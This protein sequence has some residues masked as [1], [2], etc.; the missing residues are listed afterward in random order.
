MIK[1]KELHFQRQ[2]IFIASS[3]HIGKLWKVENAH[4]KGMHYIRKKTALKFVV[5]IISNAL[6]TSSE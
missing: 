5:S 4:L 2:V 1:K 3:I 6:L